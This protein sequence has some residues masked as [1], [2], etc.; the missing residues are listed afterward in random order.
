MVL[1]PSDRFLRRL[2]AR[3]GSVLALAPL[4]PLARIP[5]VPAPAGPEVLASAQRR[6]LTGAGSWLRGPDVPEEI[7]ARAEVPAT[8]AAGRFLEA[9]ELPP[10]FDV[11][12]LA[13]MEAMSDETTLV[14]PIAERW[15]VARALQVKLRA[16][17]LGSISLQV[18]VQAQATRRVVH[19]VGPRVGGGHVEPAHAR[20]APLRSLLCAAPDASY[21]E[22]LAVAASMREALPLVVRTAISFVFPEKPEWAEEDLASALVA[23][24]QRTNL[25]TFAILFGSVRDPELLRSWIA[26]AQTWAAWYVEKY[27]CDALLRLSP[28][29]ATDVIAR[30]A[31]RSVSHRRA[32]PPE[33]EALGVSFLAL[34]TEAAGKTLAP[35][36]LHPGYGRWARDWFRAYPELAATVLP[37]FAAQ[38]SVAG[39]AARHVLDSVKPRAPGEETPLPELPDWLTAPPLPTPP[40]VVIELPLPPA[41]GVFPWREGEREQALATSETTRIMEPAMLERWRALVP[42][43]RFVDVWAQ[44]ENGKWVHWAAP[45]DEALALWN[46]DPQ[47]PQ[48]H[49]PAHMLA[50]HGDAAF[51]G[52]LARGAFDQLVRVRS[53]AVAI[54]CARA[55]RSLA[56]RRAARA[57][58]LEDPA[59]SVTG[60]L[61]YA[62]ASVAPRARSPRSRRDAENALQFLALHD[63]ATVD[64]AAARAGPAVA[65]A[66]QEWLDRDRLVGA[67]TRRE[68]R[69]VDVLPPL[70]WRDGT[71]LPRAAVERLLVALKRC[72]PWVRDPR[73]AELSERLEPASRDEFALAALFEWAIAGATS[74]SVWLAQAVLRLGTKRTLRRAWPLLDYWSRK[75][76]KRTALLLDLLEEEGSDEA[77]ALV[78]RI[79]GG[80]VALPLRMVG[81]EI[82]DAAAKKRGLTR[83][84]L[85]DRLAPTFGAAPGE[86]IRFDLGARSFHLALS[87]D[88]V[89]LLA[90]ADGRRLRQ[91]PRPGKE[92]DPALAAHAAERWRWIFAEAKTAARQQTA[93]LERA[94]LE[95]HQWSAD[96][97]RQLLLH[98]FLAILA[99]RL[100]WASAAG[101]MFRVAE[102]GTLA[103]EADRATTLPDAPVRLPHP[104]TI[105]PELVGQWSALFAD[106]GILQPFEQLGR[107]IYEMGELQQATNRIDSTNGRVLPARRVIAVL[108]ATGWTSGRMTLRKLAG[109]TAYA[110]LAATPGHGLRNLTDDR[111]QTLGVVTLYQA[112]TFAEILPLDRSEL[113]RSLDMLR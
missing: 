85:L 56:R 32:L 20:L 36:L 25:N 26:K 6:W 10:S 72:T 84:E 88:L 105:D 77:L 98:P 63:R 94:M 41:E 91:L 49:S 17:G 33:L 66:L 90:A 42:A 68:V 28:D 102:D 50:I 35:L 19:L 55:L 14:P 86:P 44:W 65:A 22:A 43:Q 109:G 39:D 107:A 5:R 15:G 87:D 27:L 62:F 81:G 104:L 16:L 67:A 76:G 60:L 24:P 11:E 47:A 37:P 46:A 61:P 96:A 8:L 4:A 103:D 80:R 101:R 7:A 69:L 2:H 51:P 92:D 97:F 111:T 108:D 18:Q 48:R 99:R 110:Y 13:A 73:F 31:Q 21:E 23:V 64:A 100:V 30:L 59:L 95:G 52:L 58:L 79:A 12:L 78:A 83:S 113:L 106:Y 34:R 38:K 1:V 89:P 53:S 74:E 3:R 93:R 9:G 70:R 75:S 112:K 71:L 45:A 57:W 29:D 40:A 54:V 82:L